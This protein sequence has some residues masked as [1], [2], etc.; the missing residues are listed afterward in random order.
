MPESKR[1][2]RKADKAW[3]PRQSAGTRDFGS[4]TTETLLRFMRTASSPAK[5]VAVLKP[6][7]LMIFE[8]ESVLCTP[9]GKHSSQLLSPSGYTLS[10][11]E[12][13]PLT[14]HLITP[15]GSKLLP[16]RVI[17]CDDGFISVFLSENKVIAKEL[18]IP[19]KPKTWIQ[20]SPIP[21]V[22][23][24][25]MIDI[26]ITKKQIKQIEQQ[27]RKRK[28]EG[29]E[30]RGISQNALNKIP[31]TKAMRKA[32]I[33]VNDGD[34]HYA[35]FIPFSFLGD[36]AQKVENMGIGTRHANAAMELVNPAIRRL[37]Y[38]KN[39]PKVVYLSAIPEW[40]PGFEKIRLLKSITYIIK[41]G[42]GND[43]KHS[44]KIAFNM[45]SLAEVCLTDV[46]PI[47]DSIIEKF[48]EKTPKKVEELPTLL[49][50]TRAI[51]MSPSFRNRAMTKI[52]SPNFDSF[53]PSP[54]PIVPAFNKRKLAPRGPLF[55]ENDLE[56]ESFNPTRKLKFD[57]LG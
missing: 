24:Q 41:D 45:L 27:T 37:L 54:A 23:M 43:F 8:G 48:S 6:P 16:S 1:R 39:G 29:M 28:R 55:K 35:H 36:N 30:P 13:G 3:H 18:N 5:K 32:G 47:K 19:L 9:T 50:P 26:P 7:Q 14:S 2:K 40:V 31:A 21:E 34:G 22:D 4:F 17:E 33:E 15:M 53:A 11:P 49:S 44:A 57:G 42:I 10:T 38:K 25:G 20:Y 12:A 46:R 56:N 51:P 52:E